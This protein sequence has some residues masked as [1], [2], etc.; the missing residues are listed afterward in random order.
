MK[1]I[2]NINPVAKPRMVRSDKWANRPVVTK[3][4]GICNLLRLQANTKGLRTLPGKIE[5]LEF[6][7]QMPKSWSNKKK[8]EMADE[9]HEQT[10]DIDNFLKFFADALA[11]EDKHI[12]YIGCLVKRWAYEGGI[13]LET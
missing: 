12:W 4:F 7:V 11:K 10:P 5:S 3:Y 9:P 6:F 8:K 2:F 1:Y 13:I